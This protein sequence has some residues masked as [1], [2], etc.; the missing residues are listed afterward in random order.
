MGL[1]FRLRLRRAAK[2]YARQLGPHLR[3]AY[4]AAEHYSMPQIR[5]AVGRLGLNADFL[6]L[7]LAA[8]L[9][10]EE[11]ASQAGEMPIYIPY[12]AARA[13]VTRF[14]SAGRFG[15]LHHY[16]SGLGMTGGLDSGSS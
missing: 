1:L 11:F 9:P 15:A 7:G 8:F 3:R 14:Q 6:A 13:L 2:R 16:E 10:E 4:G 12:D 5:A